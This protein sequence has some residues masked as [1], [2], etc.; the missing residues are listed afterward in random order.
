MYQIGYFIALGYLI[1][2]FLL[3]GSTFLVRAVAFIA[4]MI[5]SPLL[6]A[7]FFYTSK[8]KS[9][10][11]G[12]VAER[13][14]YT[15]FDYSLRGPAYMLVALLS[16]TLAKA[17]FA[18]G[19][20][21]FG[22]TGMDLNAIQTSILALKEIFLP[23][24][25]AQ[26]ATAAPGLIQTEMQMFMRFIVFIAFF[27]ML[28]RLFDSIIDELSHGQAYLG[29]TAT[30]WAGKIGRYGVRAGGIAG[31]ATFGNLGRA[32]TDS[33]SI[34][35][36]LRNMQTSNNAATRLIA[37]TAARAGD[38]LAKG[39]YD[40]ANFG[41]LKT[42]LSKLGY[43]LGEGNKLNA[44]TTGKYV[45]DAITDR[46]FKRDKSKADLVEATGKGF[47][48]VDE[49]D[50]SNSFLNR[51]FAKINSESKSL[52][53][54]IGKYLSSDSEF[55]EGMKKINNEEK[56]ASFDDAL[57]SKIS[58]FDSEKTNNLKTAASD[59]KGFDGMSPADTKIAHS[60]AEA[61]ESLKN[62]RIQ[63]HAETKALKER[64]KELDEI[65][66]KIKDKKAEDFSKDEKSE[67]AK[68]INSYE[69]SKQSSAREKRIK[70]SED[71]SG[72]LTIKAPGY[73]AGRAF[74]V[75]YTD[76]RKAAKDGVVKIN[77]DKF[78]A[79]GE[80]AFNKTLQ[81]DYMEKSLDFDIRLLE[82][83]KNAIL[84]ENPVLKRN[85]L[86][87]KEEIEF[88]KKRANNK[89]LPETERIQARIDFEREKAELEKLEDQAYG[90]F[91]N[92]LKSEMEKL[93]SVRNTITKEVIGKPDAQ[94]KFSKYAE[95]FVAAQSA[96]FSKMKQE[97]RV[98]KPEAYLKMLDNDKFIK[99]SE[100]FNSYSNPDKIKTIYPKAAKEAAKTHAAAE[101][102]ADKPAPAKKDDGHH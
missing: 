22:N 51:S 26:A 99:F 97:M 94:E 89:S 47:R 87:S 39:T 37:R 101:H 59:N 67:I 21:T 77:S 30:S 49:N 44:R 69:D 100:S 36:T 46:Q 15:L 58:S 27:E 38:R 84:D 5:L 82:P 8:D 78:K 45:T 40:A 92:K 65:A 29:K 3:I 52:G 17:M 33:R 60:Y 68:K 1:Y 32:I 73:V 7:K 57:K 53:A 28:K 23:V 62:S 80:K 31:S 6:V 11:L 48:K 70:I 50:V 66:R 34:G 41:A 79:D 61:V 10:R 81:A 88:N 24:V 102:K 75:R 91:I 13:V 42:G 63:A 16:A 35:G 25:N 72:D 74:G 83:F 55:K 90:E 18:S 9:S 64:K 19:G 20:N 85:I 54:S 14:K 93:E 4:A 96:L 12:S 2:L 76:A 71:R 98:N 43:D 56:F 95:T 86:E